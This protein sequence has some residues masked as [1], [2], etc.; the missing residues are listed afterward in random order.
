M[1]RQLAARIA[2]LAAVILVAAAV[3]LVI[4]TWM[5]PILLLAGAVWLVANRKNLA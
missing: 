2:I 1:N 4:P 5:P 3:G